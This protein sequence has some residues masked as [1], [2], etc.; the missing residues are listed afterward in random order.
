[1]NIELTCRGEVKSKHGIRPYETD[2]IIESVSHMDISE[3][4]DILQWISDETLAAYLRSRGFSVTMPE[5]KAA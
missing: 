3:N 4:F 1:M 2:V 5:E